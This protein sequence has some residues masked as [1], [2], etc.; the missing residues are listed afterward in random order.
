MLDWM[1]KSPQ[2][3]SSAAMAFLVA[4]FALR[5]VAAAFSFPVLF[6]LI[7]HAAG[8]FEYVV[9]VNSVSQTMVALSRSLAPVVSGNVL[10]SSLHLQKPFLWLFLTVIA[11][12]DFVIAILMNDPGPIQAD[13]SEELTTFAIDDDES[14]L[15]EAHEPMLKRAIDDEDDSD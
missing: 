15:E 10:S 9:L 14:V 1:P 5:T 13:K 7:N 12:V 4:V 3:V 6:I 11:A 2:G 8:S